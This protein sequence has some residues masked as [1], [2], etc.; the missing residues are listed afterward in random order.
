MAAGA[1]R[2]RSREEIAVH[3]FSPAVTVAIPL[4]AIFLQA[5]LPLR[6]H[7][8]LVFNLP[9]LITIFFAVAKRNQITGLVTGALIGTVQDA[10][11][12]LPIGLNGIALT[13]VGYAASSVGARIDVENPGSRGL[14]AIAFYMV[15][16]VIY[17]VVANGMAQQGIAW[18]WGHDFGAALANGFLAIVLFAVLDQ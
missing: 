7:F 4:L 11:T 15:H 13:V 18:R 10:L 12:H 3:R 1:Q 6:V 8:F 5:F 2:A 14:M 16:R 17:M 9:L